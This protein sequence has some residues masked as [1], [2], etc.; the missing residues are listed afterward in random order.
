MTLPHVPARR[1]AYFCQSIESRFFSEREPDAQVL[2]EYTYR[3]PLSVVTEASWIAAHLREL[4]GREVTVVRNGMDRAIFRPDGEAVAPRLATGLRVLVE[5]ALRVP[6]KRVEQTVEWCRAAGVAEIWLLTP[7]VCSE[8][9]GVQR[10]FS[11][12]PMPEVGRVM[13][14]C[15][16]LV[17]LS[18]V[19]GMF[20]PPLEMMHCG[21]TAITTDVTGHEEYM[22]HGENGFVVRRGEESQVIPLLRAL[23][24]DRGLLERLQAGARRTAEQW[25]DWQQAVAEM[26]RFVASVC[27]EQLSTDAIERQMLEHLGAALRLAGPLQATIRPEPSGSVL[28]RMALRKARQKALRKLGLGQAAAEEGAGSDRPAGSVDA[29]PPE[30]GPT[31]AHVP[32]TA[33]PVYRVCF[34]GDMRRFG[35]HVPST[36]QRLAA[37]SVDV[38]RPGDGSQ[39]AAALARVQ[40]AAPDCAF[41]FEPERVPTDW[42]ERLPG[43][44][45]GHAL[46]SP[47]PANQ[48]A[49]RARFSHE[50]KARRAL[51]HIDTQVVPGLLAAGIHAPLAFLLPVGA[52]R[53]YVRIEAA[54]WVERRIDVLLLGPPDD[55]GL[56][57]ALRGVTPNFVYVA[58]PPAAPAVAALLQQSKMVVHARAQG[59]ALDA[60][61]AVRDMLAGALVLGGRFRPDY[62]LLA[63]EHYLHFEDA[64]HLLAHIRQQLD[65]HDEL[66]VMRRCAQQFVQR[67]DADAAYVALLDRLA[68]AG[69]LTADWAGQLIGQGNAVMQ[70]AQ[71]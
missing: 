26:E 4:Y 65:Q 43:F 53:F 55:D 34:V 17:K 21:G 2:A 11:Q 1:Y 14:S 19:E 58:E 39:W 31:I 12:V 36:S 64:E 59:G 71:R 5:G 16:V 41:V 67:Y 30:P 18:T 37:Q 50:R 60:A 38:P 56:V 7:T 44:V 35:A 22:R 52:A 61:G 45:L 63:G 33:K 25:P 66:D 20:G 28:L 68:G 23:A 54:D 3:Q 49:W 57:T 29:A 46:D 62:G 48:A 24:R 6:F 8:F 40:A 32:I 47:T 70:E 13:R 42:L 69:P 9:P 51:L 27:E 15:D 10:V